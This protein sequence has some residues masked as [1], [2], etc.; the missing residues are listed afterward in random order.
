MK[1]LRQAD[2][3]L[4][5]ILP[6]QKLRPG[7]RYRRS[8]FA[9]PYPDLNED[10]G[11][12]GK[13]DGDRLLWF[14]TLTR[15]LVEP[16]CRLPDAGEVVTAEEAEAD[17]ELLELVR[18]F[19]LVP[20]DADE[21][22]RYIK[23]YQIMHALIRTK[24]EKGFT[25]LPTTACNA[26]CVYCYEEGWR[27]QTMTREMALRVVDHIEKETPSGKITLLWFGG[28]PLAAV[29]VI[30]LICRELRAKEIAFSGE[31]ITNGSLITEEVADKMSRR[32]NIRS[33]QVS[34]DGD[35]RD[36]I[37]R[38]QYVTPGDQYRG[39]FRAVRLL[40]DR[41][42]RVHIRC[43]VD[44]DNIGGIESFL[45]DLSKAVP[46]RALVDVSL[47]A[48]N[49]LRASDRA[50]IIWKKI[51]AAGP[52]LEKYGVSGK[53]HRFT[54]HD[55]RNYFCMAEMGTELILPDGSIY[56]CELFSEES[57]LGNILE[58]PADREARKNF[59]RTDRVRDKCR[60]CPFLPECTP[61]ASCPRVEARCR[62]V[63]RICFE[64]QVRR[65]LQDH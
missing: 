45:Q 22:A 6:A 52:L 43:N 2:P 59:C 14:N 65:F 40:T 39:V 32:W 30:D 9:V 57:R 54:L 63:Y 25:I 11:G 46:D 48:L 16:A 24:D 33:V 55:L 42:I 26:R 20:E 58:G 5:K 44:E 50:P 27:Q 53:D 4:H 1:E 13:R 15:Q 56:A 7:A 61:F 51:V 8:V 19:F 47:S 29:P 3:T 35:E 17:P 62:E 49:Q 64:E 38:K 10:R 34:M 28:E 21:T 31:M 60:D 36:Y 37:A 18:N 23:L 41:G 12:E